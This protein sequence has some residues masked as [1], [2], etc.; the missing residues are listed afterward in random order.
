ML[1]IA[2][3]SFWFNLAPLGINV[4]YVIARAKPGVSGGWDYYAWVIQS[5]GKGESH[6]DHRG[7]E[8][9]QCLLSSCPK[10]VVEVVTNRVRLADGDDG[11]DNMK[12][13]ERRRSSS[14]RT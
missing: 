14:A 1:R 4:I 9:R 6:V 13:Q 3:G 7:A 8:C 12:L 5:S 11:N 10:S 2:L